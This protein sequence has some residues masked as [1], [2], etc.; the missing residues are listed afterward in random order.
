M[1]YRSVVIS[2]VFSTVL[3]ILWYNYTGGIFTYDTYKWLT[4]AS[5]TMAGFVFTT[6]QLLM[7]VLGNENSRVGRIIRED[8][9]GYADELIKI[10]EISVLGYF[11]TAILGG[12][13]LLTRHLSVYLNIAV[14]WLI[15]LSTILLFLLMIN[16]HEIYEDYLELDMKD[17][18]AY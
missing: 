14:V 15:T 7:I 2:L 1:R 4:S 5:A 17:K 12:A 3:L 11:L 6:E 9:P 18:W 8:N 16:V 10:I 13:V